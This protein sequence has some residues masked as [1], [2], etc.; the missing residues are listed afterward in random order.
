MSRNALW[1]AEDAAAATAG[2][3]PG[4]WSASGVSIDSRTVRPGELFVA[5]AGPNFDGHDYVGDALAKGAAAAMVSRPL[6]G[7]EGPL[8]QVDDTLRGLERLASAARSRCRARLAGITGSVGKTGTKEAL[9]TVLA[10]QSSVHASAGSLNNHWGVPLSLARLPK[11]AA[12]GVFEL[13]MNHPGEI[14]PLV[15]QVRPHVAL[16]T[17]VELVHSEF[18]SSVEEIA[19]AKAEIFT[20]LA[21]DGLAVLNRDND[22]FDRLVAAAKAAGVENIQ[23][24]GRHEAA[25]ARLTTFAGSADCVCVS[26]HL[27]GEEVRYKVGAAG[28]HWAINSLAVL[29]VSK[30][31]GADTGLA[32]LALSR[33]RPPKGRGE[34]H[35]VDF[36]AGAFEIIDESYNASPVAMC[37]ALAVL[38]QSEI[39]P[40]GRRIAVLGDMREL[41]EDSNALHAGLADAVEA[42]LVDCLFACGPHMAALYDKVPERLRAGYAESSDGLTDKVVGAVRGG[43]VVMV[44]GSLGSRMRP[45]VDA[46]LEMDSAGRRVANGG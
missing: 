12:Y 19:D 37:A 24:F 34:R 10:E 32:A 28:A 42:G 21:P 15:A 46:L 14:A 43:D 1:T 41:G 20:G 44:K 39:G 45:I 5:L 6:P 2:T 8:L 27:F 29:L 25:D 7:V 13:G 22:Q 30:A 38:A 16:I 26:A 18:F 40:R 35:S 33:V 36:G 4:G 31:L 23:T 17:N 9:R 3:G 11:D